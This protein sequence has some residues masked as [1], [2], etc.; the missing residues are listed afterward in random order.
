VSE[1]TK[2]V[3][4]Y[5]PILLARVMSNRVVTD[6]FLA[7]FARRDGEFKAPSSEKVDSRSSRE[8]AESEGTS[9]HTDDANVVDCN[10]FQK[11]GR[12]RLTGS[13]LRGFPRPV[14]GGGGGGGGGGM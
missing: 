2:D 10:L 8:N 4:N 12:N 11:K 9:F 13:T 7:G 5:L 1:E 14:A 6:A 3:I